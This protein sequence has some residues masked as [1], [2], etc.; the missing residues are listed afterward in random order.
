MPSS[1]S[2]SGPASPRTGAPNLPDPRGADLVGERAALPP[3]SHKGASADAAGS[4]A[5]PEGADTLF[6]DAVLEQTYRHLFGPTSQ[7]AAPPR[8]QVVSISGLTEKL[9]Y[10]KPADLKLVKEAFHFSDEAH[11]G[12]YRQS[13]EPYITHPVAVAEICADRKSVV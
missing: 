11:L 3:K 4:T 1:A 8:Q 9:S 13:G 7:P 5:K 6:I 2:G 12:Q 10:L